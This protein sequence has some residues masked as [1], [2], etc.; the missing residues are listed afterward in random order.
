MNMIIC[1]LIILFYISFLYIF[2]PPIYLLQYDQ[3]R[4]FGFL[5]YSIIII[6]SL[7]RNSFIMLNKKTILFIFFIISYF[8]I[9]I[10]FHEYILF[11]LIEFSM[12]YLFAYSTY[13]YSNIKHDKKSI[14]LFY[15]ILCLMPIYNVIEFFISVL[16][17]FQTD[18]LIGWHGW[19]DNYRFF[20]SML[21]LPICL[22]LYF[23]DKKNIF[24]KYFILLYFFYILMLFFDGARSVLLSILISVILVFYIYPDKRKTISISIVLLFL[25]FIAHKLYLSFTSVTIN[26][27]LRGSTSGRYELWIYGINRFLEKPFLGHGGANF[28]LDTSLSLTSP[29]NFLIQFIAEWGIGGVL[30]ICL[31]F[32]LYFYL[33]ENRE[34]I[35]PFIFL[36][37]IAILIDGLFSGLF[38]LPMSQMNFM[39][40][41]GLL[42]NQINQHRVAGIVD[43][44][45]NYQFYKY[46]FSVVALFC[47]GYFLLFH[48]EDITCLNCMGMEGVNTPRF[49][50]GGKSLHLQEID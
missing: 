30:I 21:L 39:L 49:W 9:S 38:I 46:I 13:M 2:I 50:R 28:S 14:S 25:A 7:K 36:C 32:F 34:K 17:S 33:F 19:A 41:I 1:V 45:F 24:S 3:S 22:S 6:I 35:S 4:I 20:D 47:I 29:H 23:F 42:L 43:P 27:V 44:S 15:L 12:L 26:S 5:I 37:A 8:L 10:F 48:W 16:I 31:L 18:K 11:S 40:V